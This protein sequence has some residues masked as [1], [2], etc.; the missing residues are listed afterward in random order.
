MSVLHAFNSEPQD[1]NE[2]F[3]DSY[4]VISEGEGLPS[5]FLMIDKK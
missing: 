4:V 1:F 3:I 5:S 2:M